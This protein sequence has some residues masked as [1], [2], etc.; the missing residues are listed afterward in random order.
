MSDAP[1]IIVGAAQAGLQIADSLRGEGWEGGI[2][3][4]GDESEPP[5]HRPPLSKGFLSGEFDGE[6]LTIRSPEYFTGKGI[7]TMFGHRAVA[8]D[9]IAK[10]V[11]LEN[12]TS[13]PYSKLALTTGARPRLL[14][15]PGADLVGV[16]VLR[17]RGDVLAI[18]ARLE[19]AQNIV[20]VG[21]GFI[22]L[23]V[24][25]V[26]RGLGKHV[27]VLE[28]QDRL[29][30]RVV[31][32]A[33]SD[34]YKN[35]HEG[36]GTR[37]LLGAKLDRLVGEDGEVK[38]AVLADGTS[39]PAQ[40]V[41]VAIG[42][43]PN[44]E[45]AR[46]AGLA[47]DNGIL[48]DE[49]AITSDPDIVASGD[50]ANHFNRFMGGR[51]RLE[52]VQN[53]ADQGRTAAASLVGKQKPYGTVPWFWSDQYDVKLQMAGRSHGHDTFVFRGDPM[54]SKFSVFYFI[55]SVLIGADSLNSSSDHMTV[56][57]LLAGGTA[58]NPIQAADP[59]F[60]LK[61]LVPTPPAR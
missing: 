50:C 16:F 33:L 61:L 6:R 13:L 49:C 51:V 17:T 4:I 31:S 12:G 41:L 36:R 53:A 29:M 18:R 60:D 57:K 2:V 27:T 9:R 8:I 30:P 43:I 47:C 15:A 5:Y 24:A 45:L 40:I 7:T 11:T 54:G 26:A 58:L 25:A 39:L 32:P 19:G 22:G 37:I 23:E 44:D 14:T 10:T 28:A 20:I 52:S 56:R 35:L 1:I 34:F 3:L 46:E 42:V 48:V 38:A 21:G 55:D 59:T